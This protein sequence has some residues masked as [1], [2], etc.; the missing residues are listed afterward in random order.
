MLEWLTSGGDFRWQ[1]IGS[2]VRASCRA[3]S[4]LQTRRSSRSS[5]P[6]KTP[7]P[8]SFRVRTVAE[9]QWQTSRCWLEI[10]GFKNSIDYC[11]VLKTRCF[12]NSQKLWICWIPVLHWSHSTFHASACQSQHLWSGADQL[13]ADKWPVSNRRKMKLLILLAVLRRDLESRRIRS[14]C[15]S[16]LEKVN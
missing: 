14:L 12:P 1:C 3:C 4:S 10:T 16:V 8:H 15:Y 5:P 6:W 13:P 7:F 11:K 9:F 2:S